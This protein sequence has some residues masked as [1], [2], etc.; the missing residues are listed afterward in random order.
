MKESK[1]FGFAR[2]IVAALGLGGLVLSLGNCGAA[3]VGTSSGGT[4]GTSTLP[5]AVCSAG[6]A[7]CKD[8]GDCAKN[9]PVCS[10]G[11]AAQC[12]DGKCV[13]A[14]QSR[15]ILACPCMEH[16]VGPCPLAGGGTGQGVC[17]RKT[18]TS[19]STFWCSCS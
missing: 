14:A 4:A 5:P 3:A 9:V 12:V 11:A 10:T 6:Q 19:T 2:K 17:G 16:E 15:S 1:R 13:F 7:P 18:A 8:I